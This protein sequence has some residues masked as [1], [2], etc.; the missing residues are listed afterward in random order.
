MNS[1]LRF[2]TFSSSIDSWETLFRKACEFADE[3]GEKDILS[4][5]QSVG[6]HNR[7]VVTVWYWRRFEEQASEQN[8]IDISE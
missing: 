1:K 7:G 8:S 5:S 6:N 3:I 2:K 4:V